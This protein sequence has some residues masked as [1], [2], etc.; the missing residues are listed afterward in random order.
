MPVQPLTLEERID[1]YERRQEQ[2]VQGMNV[3]AGTLEAQTGMLRE[4][5]AWL[6]QPPSSDL[7]D[8][9]K[10]LIVRTDTVS[11]IAV[12]LGAKMDA[13]PE[14]LA[15]AVSGELPR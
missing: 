2:I 10:A 14:A 6:K 4:L 8:L 13:L 7:P 3:I 5:A 11:E 9:L 12:Q 1:R 15:R